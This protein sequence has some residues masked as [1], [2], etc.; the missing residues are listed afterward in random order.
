VLVNHPGS[1]LVRITFYFH[2]VGEEEVC[3]W[4]YEGIFGKEAGFFD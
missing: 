3:V 2:R 4:D 1:G